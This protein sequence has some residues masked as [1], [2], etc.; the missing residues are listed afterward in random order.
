MGSAT[1]S[2]WQ[3]SRLAPARSL[4]C[5]QK[6]QS[7]RRNTAMIK[8]CAHRLE[9][10]RRCLADEL[11]RGLQASAPPE[12]A[13]AAA[14]AQ[15]QAGRAAPLPARAL[16]QNLCSQMQ[17]GATHARFCKLVAQHVTPAAE[18]LPTCTG[19]LEDSVWPWPYLMDVLAHAR[20]QARPAPDAAPVPAPPAYAARAGAPR[21]GVN[22]F[23]PAHASRQ[24]LG[25]FA[26]SCKRDHHC[27]CLALGLCPARRIG[28]FQ[29]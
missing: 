24:F 3:G 6:A 10:L 2:S 12:A 26:A 29:G 14:V 17:P 1:G 21:L 13:R 27:W 9:A 18:Q 19:C 25:E 8:Q 11:L 4:P 7:I 15:P 23:L 28:G 5:I 16:G 20:G 22:G